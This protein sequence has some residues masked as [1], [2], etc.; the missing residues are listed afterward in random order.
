MPRLAHT[1]NFMCTYRKPKC[2]ARPSNLRLPYWPIKPDLFVQS[3]IELF[4]KSRF[5]VFLLQKEFQGS[6]RIIGR[7]IVRS[8]VIS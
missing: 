6:H 3:E 1:F 8:Y 4:S 2:R 7:S 5:S